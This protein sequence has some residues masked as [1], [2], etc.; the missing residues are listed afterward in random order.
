MQKLWLLMHGVT[1]QPACAFSATTTNSLCL[2]S[3]RN[4]T[5]EEWLR[6]LPLCN[7]KPR[8]AVWHL[9]K[10]AAS[11]IT[12][13]GSG[14]KEQPKWNVS[15][16]RVFLSQLKTQKISNLYKKNTKGAKKRLSQNVIRSGVS[17]EGSSELFSL[18]RW[19]GSWKG[20]VLAVIKSNW[21]VD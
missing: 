14:R 4:V 20:C 12:L 3:P 1:P 11:L 13:W 10:E 19:E 18:W 15:W 5:T 16:P 9:R 21:P 6:Q 7:K 2:H 17:E 8:Q